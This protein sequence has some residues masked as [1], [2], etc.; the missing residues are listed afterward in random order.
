M[1]FSV[2]TLT[3][4][5]RQHVPTAE[6]TPVFSTIPTG[7]FNVSYRVELADRELVLR[8]APPRSAV[9]VFY[10]RLMMRQE[11]QLHALL[12]AETAVPVPRVLAFDDTH[13]LID[14][15]YILM[16][17]LP[18]LPWTAVPHADEHRVLI[19]VGHCL[20]QVHRLH[21]TQYG[22]LGPHRPM[23][24]QNSWVD[25]FAVMWGKLIADVCGVGYYSDEEADF[26]RRL[27]DHYLLYFDRPVLPSLLHMD[28][29]HQNILLDDDGAVTGLVD[30]DRALWGDPEIE[31]AVLD[32]CGI[33][34]AA[35][36]EGYGQERDTSSDARVRQLFYLLYEMQKYIVIR[37]GRNHDPA[38]ARRARQQVFQLV[39]QHLA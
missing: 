39:K 35:F 21:A 8:I 36:W 12:L 37:H 28:V 18:G 9:F 24:P 20:A 29:W 31:F 22:Y 1:T 7:K 17:A 19:Q 4:L 2:D 3:A 30:W 23:V 6:E 32:Y 26:M 5:I 38:G 25:A 33:S 11:P 15:D 10:E 16:T 34:G 14:R 27:L 13:R